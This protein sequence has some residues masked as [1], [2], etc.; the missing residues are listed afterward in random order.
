MEMQILKQE[1][2]IS[3]MFE[4]FLEAIVFFYKANRKI[5]TGTYT[6]MTEEMFLLT[7]SFCCFSLQLQAALLSYSVSCPFVKMQLD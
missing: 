2:M 3:K 7:M 5:R 6:Q 1:V 4:F